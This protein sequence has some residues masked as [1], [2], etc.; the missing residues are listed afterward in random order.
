MPHGGHIKDERFEIRFGSFTLDGSSHQTGDAVF[1]LT[2]PENLQHSRASTY[3]H[4]SHNTQH[5][6][7]KQKSTVLYAKEHSAQPEM[8]WGTHHTKPNL[9]STQEMPL[10]FKYG[11]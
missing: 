1:T 10:C 9:K 4:N 7:E 3:L 5:K 8:F 6:R 2:T 11:E